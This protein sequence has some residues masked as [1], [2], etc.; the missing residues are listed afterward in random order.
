MPFPILITDSFVFFFFMQ[1]E[2]KVILSKL[3]RHFK[4]ELVPGQRFKIKT[5]LMNSPIDK[6]MTVIT[7]R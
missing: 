1:M 7:P 2:T 6:C 3:L 5:E 4:F